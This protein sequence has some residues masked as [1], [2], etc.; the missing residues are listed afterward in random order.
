[1]YGFRSVL[2]VCEVYLSWNERG[3]LSTLLRKFKAKGVASLLMPE[4]ALYVL[5][6]RDYIL[7]QAHTYERL[8][9][10]SAFTIF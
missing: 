5:P 9:K 2:N 10:V 7:Y 8:E 6:K 3:S 1:M 4:I